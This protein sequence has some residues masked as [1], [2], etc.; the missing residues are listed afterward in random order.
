MHQNLLDTNNKLKAEAD[1]FLQEKGLLEVLKKLCVY[2]QY[3]Y[4]EY[5]RL[6]MTTTL[7]IRIDTKLKNKLQKKFETEGLD[8]SA[9]LRLLAKDAVQRKEPLFQ[10][11]TVNGFTPEYEKRLLADVRDA[12]LHGKY[13]TDVKKMLREI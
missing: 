1:V 2:W 4:K 9:G 11:R 7:Q 5:N 12:E 10:V 6:I 8:L 3:H 13:Y